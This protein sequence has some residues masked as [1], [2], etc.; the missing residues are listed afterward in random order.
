MKGKLKHPLEVVIF[1]DEEN[2]MSGSIG[3][4]SKKPEIKAFIEL[5][6]EQGPVLDHQGVD[7]GIVEGIVG[8]RRCSV[9]IFGFK[10]I[11]RELLP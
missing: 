1:Y 9:K 2:T 3:Y 11:M 10:K 5:H 7:I 4:C 8:Q 6:V